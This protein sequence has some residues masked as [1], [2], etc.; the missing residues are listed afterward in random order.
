MFGNLTRRR[1]LARV[2]AAGATAKAG[3]LLH[4]G[5]SAY[6]APPVEKPA[7]LGGPKAKRGAFDSWPEFDHTKNRPSSTYYAAV[8]GIAAMGRS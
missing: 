7:L 2:P 4:S 6:A 1:F 5:A 3:V 8:T